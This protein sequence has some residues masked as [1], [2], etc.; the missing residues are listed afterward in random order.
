MSQRFIKYIPSEKATWL[1][2]NYPNAFL[3][4]MLIA[5]RA[6][7]E[8]GHPDGLI[9]GDAILGDPKKAGLSRQ[10][11]RTAIEKLE[12]FGFI[13]IISNGKQ[14]FLRE[15]STIRITINS[16]LVNLCNSEIWD[17]NS[18]DTNQ[19]NNQRATNEQ[20]QTRKN[21]KEKEIKETNKEKIVMLPCNADKSADAAYL[22]L[23]HSA[24]EEDSEALEAWFDMHRI[25]VDKPV[26]KNWLTIYGLEKTLETLKLFEQKISQVR[27]P[28]GWIT[29]ALR[30]NYALKRKYTEQNHDFA[31]KFKMQN[32]LEELKL[33][34]S[35]CV[36]ERTGNDYQY[37]L[38]PDIFQEELK[39]KFSH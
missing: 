35:Y 27:N 38:N 14:F 8:N 4:L 28:G 1:R 18:N 15:K 34:K 23:S 31:L 16:Y 39:R 10:K 12:E 9:I 2:E 3:L 33:H 30:Q 13:K 29:T 26:I 19:Q 37:S 36:D 22:P 21:K 17:I 32:N 24:K 11:Y 5:E 6:R 7:R 20:P 25:I